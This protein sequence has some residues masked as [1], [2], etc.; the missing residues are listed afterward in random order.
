MS[1][2]TQAQYLTLVVGYSEGNFTDEND[3][4][5]HAE[6]VKECYDEHI[7]AGR[8]KKTFPE[9][10]A[11]HQRRLILSSAT[12]TGKITEDIYKNI[13][14][15]VFGSQHMVRMQSSLGSSAFT[16]GNF[17][18]PR[19]ISR[20]AEDLFPSAASLSQRKMHA[21]YSECHFGCSLTFHMDPVKVI[22]VLLQST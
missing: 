12:L 21:P 1:I 4:L 8:F 11:N 3:K 13:K 17:T 20:G 15:N 19:S 9:A 6:S 14:N 7:K 2:E 5:P 10:F 16:N 22:T 18:K